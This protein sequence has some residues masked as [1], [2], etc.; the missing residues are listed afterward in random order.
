MAIEVFRPSCNL[1]TIKDGRGAIFSFVPKAPI[2]E[3]THQFIKSGRIRGNHCHPE[4]DE[5]ILLVDGEGTVVEK[6]IE[7]GEEKFV[8]MSKGI[9][10]FI[11]RN[12]YHVFLAI[13]DC[14][15]ISFLT[16]KWND[17]DKPIIH[18]NLGFGTGDFGD[19]NSDFYN[20]QNVDNIHAE[21]EK[22]KYCSD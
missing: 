11:P 12:T 19:P 6:D 7:S 3:W 16:K 20:K 9:C 17:C 13:T 21:Q 14:E 10:V 8:Y 2:M 18:E 1:S 5:Y 15:S 4:F 22:R